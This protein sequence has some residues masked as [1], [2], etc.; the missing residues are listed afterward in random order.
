VGGR[1]DR[2]APNSGRRKST[3]ADGLVHRSEYAVRAK[4][5]DQPGPGGG[6]LCAFG[7]QPCHCDVDI[8]AMQLVDGLLQNLGPGE[9]DIDHPVSLDHNKPA[10]GGGLCDRGERWIACRPTFFLPVR[11]LSRLFRRLSLSQMSSGWRETAN[12]VMVAPD[13]GRLQIALVSA[14]RVIPIASVT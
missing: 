3:A 9:V 8:A 5:V 6:L 14:H 11:V 1:A 7:L 12:R 2:D 4:D 10:P 13:V